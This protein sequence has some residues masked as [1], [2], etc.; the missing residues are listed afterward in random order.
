MKDDPEPVQIV[1]L[2]LLLQLAQR[3]FIDDSHLIPFRTVIAVAQIVLSIAQS[4]DDTLYKRQPQLARHA[5][6]GKAII[7]GLR[8]VHERSK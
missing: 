7:A 1:R 6:Q 2:N 8:F 3:A 4:C 5:T